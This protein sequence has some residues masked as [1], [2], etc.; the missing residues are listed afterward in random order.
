MKAVK[1]GYNSSRN[2]EVVVPFFDEDIHHARSSCGMVR[3]VNFGNDKRV[4]SLNRA[5]MVFIS[6]TLL[7]MIV[8]VFYYIHAMERTSYVKQGEIDLSAT[9]FEQK[10]VIALDGEWEFYWNQLLE[11]ADFKQPN[12]GTFQYLEVPGNWSSDQEGN[13]YPN[14][15]YATYRVTLH[16]IPNTEYFGLKKANIRNSSKLFV[17]GKLV[18]EDGVVSKQLAGSVAGNNSE[19]VLFE[20][21]DDTAEIIIQVA[22]HEYIV[23]GIAKSV[24]F[25]KQE[26]LMQQHAQHVLFEFAMILIVVVIGLFYLFLFLASKH[27]RTKEPATLPLALSCLIIGVMNGIYSE[28]I[29]TVILPEITLNSTFRFGHFMSGLSMIMVVLVVNKVNEAFL[30]NRLRNSLFIFYGVFL[31]CALILPLDVYLATLT[32]YLVSTVVFL[33]GLWLWIVALF[34]RRKFQSSYP[35]EHGTLIVAVFSISL[36]WFDM[37]LYSLG[38]KIDLLVSFLTISVYSISLATLFIVR[39]AISY[40]KNEELSIKLIETFSTL[41]QTTKEVQRNELAFLQAQIKPHFLFNAL[42]SIISLCY[43]EGEKAAKLLTELSNY[44]KRSFAVDLNTEFITIE[45]EL[46]L[47]EAFIEIEKA[48]FGHRIKARY[49]IDSDV[50]PLQIT[51]LVIEPLIE[52][53]IRHGI[54]KNKQGGE[55]KLTIKKQP[56]GIYISVEDNGK[57]ID[58]EQLERIRQGEMDSHASHGNGVSLKNVYT[59]LR[60]VYDVEL[61]FDSTNYGTKV[62]FMIPIQE[63]REEG[64]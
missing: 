46:K 21:Q 3:V 27:Y 63:S 60:N 49:D 20:L 54:L 38:F 34:F 35:V 5:K 2:A 47:I 9:D 13:V 52:N 15:G 12:K 30:P 58:R 23:G 45:N 8:L 16:H 40:K 56:K 59:R 62:S 17:N 39:Y 29:I 7:V 61:S 1:K 44:L 32:F 19:V 11:P 14:K 4:G 36:F 48:R 26:A 18:L 33:F 22:N 10:G 64:N 6:A 43:T 41:D 53:A 42:S 57:G 25:G 51:P 50:Y 28:R 31:L 24:F 37:I 55:V